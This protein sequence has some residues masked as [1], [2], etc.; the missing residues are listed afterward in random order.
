[1]KLFWSYLTLQSQVFYFDI[2]SGDDASLYCAYDITDNELAKSH[3]RFLVGGRSKT[4]SD[5]VAIRFTFPERPASLVN[6]LTAL[7]KIGPHWNCTMWH[8]R[9]TGGDVGRVLVG[10]R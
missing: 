10:L 3:T 4:V 7:R 1:V 8:Y 6:F 2:N 5:E 9:Y